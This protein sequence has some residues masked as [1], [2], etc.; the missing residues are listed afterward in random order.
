[1][2]ATESYAPSL[3]LFIVVAVA[4]AVLATVLGAR[5]IG[6]S[7]RHQLTYVC[8]CSSLMALTTFFAMHPEPTAA[9]Y[10]AST[11]GISD[12]LWLTRIRILLFVICLIGLVLMTDFLDGSAKWLGPLGGFP[13]IAFFGIFSV[14]D[15]GGSLSERIDTLNHMGTG[16]WLSPVIA[17]WFIYGFLRYLESNAGSSSRFGWIKK[18]FAATVG[19]AA[20]L[21]AI[22]LIS[23]TMQALRRL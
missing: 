14:A 6:I 22:G 8:V 20:C 16:V 23:L 7:T 15:G 12:F 2:V 19:W 1:M 21:C 11:V 4:W 9:N 10:P 3:T 5:E 18:V 13:L 17:I